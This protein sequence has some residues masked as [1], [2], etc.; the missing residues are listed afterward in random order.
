MKKNI[1]VYIDH[2]N[3]MQSMEALG[4]KDID[5][6]GLMN[7]LKT[8]KNVSRVYVYAGYDNK[9]RKKELEKLERHGYIV[10][11]KKVMQYPS[12]KMQK[13]HKCSSCKKSC[14]FTI[15]KKGRRK[16]NCDAELTLDVIN[17]GVRKKYSGIIVFS[18]D[19]DFSRV[20]EYVAETLVKSVNV[21]APMGEKA[22]NRTSTKVKSLHNK[23]IIKVDALEGIVGFNGYGI[24]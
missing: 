7:W 14:S 13:T 11:K 19:G 10:D 15:Q 2:S 20:Y 8:K 5:W 12:E 16:A 6:P 1:F 18:G 4:F 17:D 23:G 9:E 22:G 24:K 3:L 21:I